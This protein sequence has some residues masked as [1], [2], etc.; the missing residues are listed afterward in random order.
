[1]NREVVTNKFRLYTL[2]QES[3]NTALSYLSL[4]DWTRIGQ[5]VDD[6]VKGRTDQAVRKLKASFHRVLTENKLL[7]Y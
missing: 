4:S 6:V 5:L 3:S 1:M 7:R 2:P